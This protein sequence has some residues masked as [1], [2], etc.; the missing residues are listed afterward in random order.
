MKKVLAT[1][2]LSLS[3]LMVNAQYCTPT[4]GSGCASWGSEIDSVWVTGTQGV[5]I[6]NTGSGC[7]GS[8]PSFTT[9]FTQAVQAFPGDVLNIKLGSSSATYMVYRVW[10]DWNNDLQFAAT[11][12]ALT[13]TAGANFTVASTYT[14]PATAT[15][16]KHRMRII[17]TTWTLPLATEACGNTFWDGE[18][19]DYDI[20]ILSNT[21][22]TGTPTAGTLNGG[23]ASISICPS[24]NQNL[25]VSGNT[26]ANGLVYQ[27]QS[28]AV[29]ANSWTNLAGATA[30]FYVAP[31]A[32]G[33]LDYRLTLT[34][35]ASGGS[36]SSTP[37]TLLVETP[38]VA[39]VPYFQSFENWTSYCNTFDVPS[40]KAWIGNPVTGDL[41]WRRDDLG[42][43]A[44]WQWTGGGSYFPTGTHSNHSARIH[45]YY[46][47]GSGNLDLHIDLS[48][49]AGTKTISFDHISTTW[50]GLVSLNV[51]LST[52]GGIS[53]T[54]LAS[55]TNTTTS[56]F[57]QNATITTTSNASNAVLRFEGNSTASYDGD[58]GID[59]LMITAPCSGTPVAGII[60]DTTACVNDSF[61]VALSGNFIATGLAYAWQKAPSAT[62][63]WITYATT[64]VPFS[65]SAQAVA[66]FYRCVV[67][68]S[69]S[70]LQASTPAVEISM[71]PFYYCY[72]RTAVPNGSGDN[73]DIG[74]VFIRKTTATPTEVVIENGVIIDTINNLFANETYSNFQY[75]MPINKLQRDSAYE[76]NVSTMSNNSWWF[77]SDSRVFIDYNRDGIFQ[78]SEGVLSGAQVSPSYTSAGTIIVPSTALP[79]ITGLRVIAN[80]NGSG[81]NIDACNSY[82][83]GES[84]DYLVEI[85]KPQCQS[86]I[87][88]GNVYLSDSLLCPGYQAVL[89]DTNYTDTA[90]FTG[91]TR[92]WQQST[93]GG[94]TW[95]TITSATADTFVATPNTTTQYRV[96]MVCIIGDTAYSTPVQ[97]TLINSNACY[98][99]SAAQWGPLDSS[100][101]GAFGIGSYMFTYAGGGSHIG[102]PSAIR[103]RTDVST[104]P[105]YLI[106]LYTD[107]LYNL[108]FYSILRNDYHAD[109]KVTMFIDYNGVFT[110]VSDQTNYILLGSFRTPIS[111]LLNTPTGLRIIS[112]DNTSAN[113][114]SDDG[115]GL[116][117]SG[118]TEDYRVRFR[119]KPFIPLNVASAL[120]VSNVNVYP[121]PTT[122]MVFIDITTKQL[123][124]L[125]II[126]TNATGQ[127]VYRQT[128]STVDGTFSISL[129]LGNLAKGVYMLKIQSEKGSIIKSLLIGN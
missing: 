49:Q 68:C 122:G 119:V 104:N 33:S 29:G 69:S 87:S 53:F 99:A 71:R 90:T 22:C 44:A 88:A 48:T 9:Y 13:L 97:I 94:S 57:W 128:N 76:C 24:V 102:N 117:T 129:D 123:K 81:S 75:N 14:V 36:N 60:V 28:S 105:A 16:G 127:E 58:L 103:Q 67:T 50:S 83:A 70:G 1:L 45:S 79:G 4:F 107:S 92:V 51:L 56:N 40:D 55:Y 108:T 78:S 6:A 124:A 66:T 27:W 120:D 93:N 35:T 3:V 54:P 73:I 30:P 52:N 10:V 31:S 17:G 25:F 82:W 115:V 18:A 12:S 46:G 111:P 113:T 74:R 7:N 121:N 77:N 109:A 37:I 43:S 96:R 118:E 34:C 100:D 89:I 39:T 47:L 2:I 63:P 20:E 91:L 5:D 26:N 62:G 72:C 59:N 19:E 101:N 11:E 23:L 41:A 110:G 85:I 116:Y 95:T 84:E 42:A 125:N 86:P 98:P 112:N 80:S 126:V 21:P 114:A 65:K 106:D 32:A 64:T 15:V 38:T 61:D 8:A